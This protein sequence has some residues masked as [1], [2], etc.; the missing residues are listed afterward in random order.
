MTQDAETLPRTLPP[1]R[2]TPRCGHN[3]SRDNKHR[4]AVQSRRAGAAFDNR[5]VRAVFSITRS[6]LLDEAPSI[7]ARPSTPADAWYWIPAGAEARLARAT[8]LR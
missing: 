8:H 6:R 1:R 7:V 5:R 2:C 4:H 3:M